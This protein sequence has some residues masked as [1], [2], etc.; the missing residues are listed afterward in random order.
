VAST[1]IKALSESRPGAASELRPTT[2]AGAPTAVAPDGIDASTTLPHPILARLPMLML[3]KM[4][5]CAPTS[6][7][8]NL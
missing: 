1:E 8:N 7:C 5:A 4:D 2:L 6:T 3:P